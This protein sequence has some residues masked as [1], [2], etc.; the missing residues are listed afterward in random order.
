MTNH[1]TQLA[2]RYERM[3]D[4]NAKLHRENRS[5]TKKIAELE[6]QLEAEKQRNR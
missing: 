6:R 3:K 4:E 1:L 5:L 2:D